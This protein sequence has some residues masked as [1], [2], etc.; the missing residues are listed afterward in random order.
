[1]STLSILIP[2][3]PERYSLLRRLQGILHP[4]VQKHGIGI[5]YND[6]GRQMSIG[7]KRNSLLAR[8]QTEYF[9]FIDDDDR[10]SGD[11]LDSIMAAIAQNPDCVTFTGW[12]TTNGNN[13][14]DFVIKLGEKYEERNNVYYRFP[15]HLCPMRASLVRHIKFPHIVAGEDYSWARMIHER[16]LLK[17]SVHIEKDLYFYEFNSYKSP[18]G[19]TQR[20]R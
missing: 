16:R 12:M 5:H 9:V 3:L 13:K 7:E 14:K 18:Y 20:V 6:A 1:M 8:V 2:T 17:T 15:N 19:S 4:Q 11:Y 10:V